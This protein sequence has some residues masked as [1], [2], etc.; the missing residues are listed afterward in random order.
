M[1]LRRIL[2]IPELNVLGHGLVTPLIDLKGSNKDDHSPDNLDW[3]MLN[4]Q[5]YAF[6]YNSF[7]TIYMQVVNLDGEL[8]MSIVYPFWGWL[9]QLV[10]M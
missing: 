4:A 10:I 1:T 3:K 2:P 8:F 5:C 6:H 7:L 9:D